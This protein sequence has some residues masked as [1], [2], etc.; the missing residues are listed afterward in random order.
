MICAPH[1]KDGE[2][3]RHLQ[4]HFATVLAEEPGGDRSA[5]SV[6]EMSPEEFIR[7]ANRQT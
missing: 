6:A 2:G 5:R 7:N 1:T 3:A 4:E